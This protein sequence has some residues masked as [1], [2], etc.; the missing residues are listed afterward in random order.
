[1]WVCVSSFTSLNPSAPLLV[2]LFEG[3]VRYSLPCLWLVWLLQVCQLLSLPDSRWRG[4]GGWHSEL[5]AHFDSPDSV[6]Q[7]PAR[8]SVTPR[9]KAEKPLSIPDLALLDVIV[10]VLTVALVFSTSTPQ[11]MCFFLLACPTSWF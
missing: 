11:R 1:M 9:V 10:E 8:S 3:S 4:F 6:R 7:R 5:Q 2:G